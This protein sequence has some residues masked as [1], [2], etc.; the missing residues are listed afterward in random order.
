[1][2]DR[3]RFPDREVDPELAELERKKAQVFEKLKK[4]QPCLRNFAER[5]FVARSAEEEAALKIAVYYVLG[6]LAEDAVKNEQ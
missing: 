3:F 2:I 5:G 6:L 1:M 4:F